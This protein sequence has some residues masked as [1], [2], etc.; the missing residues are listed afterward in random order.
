MPKGIHKG[1]RR[2]PSEIQQGASR[3]PKREPTGAKGSPREPL[4]RPRPKVIKKTLLFG[5]HLEA[6][7]EDLEALSGHS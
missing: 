3:E 5:P 4:G 6:K 2:D 1:F 7:K